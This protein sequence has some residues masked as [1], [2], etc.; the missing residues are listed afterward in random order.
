M[1]K[2]IDRLNGLAVAAITDRDA[3]TELYEHFFPRVYRFLLSKTANEDTADEVVSRTFIKMYEHLADYNP[4]R[5]AFSTWLFRIAI[6]ELKM[7]WRSQQY[8][9]EVEQE[10]DEEF[11]P[12]AP[13]Y[14]EP[15]Q[16]IL[17]QETQKQIQAALEKLPERERKVIE[18]FYWLNYPPRKIAEVL[19]LTPNHVSVILNRAKNKLK[20]FLS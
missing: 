14:E 11:N 20:N 9:G 4:E 1:E 17:Q 15:E 6:N 13:N 18:M 10:W 8:R 7:F 3:F 2:E 16:K 19:D 5:A 12:A